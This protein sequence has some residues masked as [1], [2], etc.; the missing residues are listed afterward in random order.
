MVPSHD[1]CLEKSLAGRLF[2][3]T[4]EKTISEINHRVFK[5]PLNSRPIKIVTDF[6]LSNKISLKENY[7]DSF[8]EEL[9][10]LPHAYYSLKWRRW[11]GT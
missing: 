6:V 5:T 9:K 1:P 4:S 7:A 3:H 10:F 8:S 2:T 11:Q